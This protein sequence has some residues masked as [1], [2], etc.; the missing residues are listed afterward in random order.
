L[1]RNAGEPAAA[2]GRMLE[3][4]AFRGKIVPAGTSA[5]RR[6]E[7]GAGGGIDDRRGERGR[8]GVQRGGAGGEGG[9]VGAEAFGVGFGGGQR[10]I[11]GRGLAEVRRWRGAIRL[12]DRHH[13]RLRRTAGGEREREEDRRAEGRGPV[14]HALFLGKAGSS[15]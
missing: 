9:G 2:C 4:N 12:G 11:E 15:L 5:R 14:A 6:G 10:G 3:I 8:A 7:A 13:G 1:L